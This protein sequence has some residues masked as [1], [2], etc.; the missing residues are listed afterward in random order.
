MSLDYIIAADSFPGAM[1]FCIFFFVLFLEL[2]NT[3]TKQRF[4]LLKDTALFLE[5]GSS[6]KNLILLIWNTLCADTSQ[7]CTSSEKKSNSIKSASS[8][9]MTLPGKQKASPPVLLGRYQIPTASSNSK[10]SAHGQVWIKKKILRYFLHPGMQNHRW[11]WKMSSEYLGWN[12]SLSPTDSPLGIILKQR[13]V[14]LHP[15]TSKTPV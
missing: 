5:A 11:N 1:E 3:K 2:W 10:H 7:C 4:C 9:N 12:S 13:P 6:I 14:L 15:E 8:V